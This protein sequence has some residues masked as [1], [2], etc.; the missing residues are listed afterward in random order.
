MTIYTT[1]NNL[2]ARDGPGNAGLPRRFGSND[3]TTSHDGDDSSIRLRLPDGASTASTP[4]VIVGVDVRRRRIYYVK[5]E[6]MR[7]P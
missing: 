7:T 2:L 4:A 1:Q 5:Q 6:P 3:A